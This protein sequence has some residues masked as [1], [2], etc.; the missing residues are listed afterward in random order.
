[1]SI[2]AVPRSLN[3]FGLLQALL[4]DTWVPPTSL[5]TCLFPGQRFQSRYHLQLQAASVAT[6]KLG[7]LAFQL[8]P[9]WFPQRLSAHHRPQ[10]LVS[11]LGRS[12]AAFPPAAGAQ[13]VQL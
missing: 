8:P 12:P 5:R 2:N 4:T 9:S 10:R 1:M 6:P 13:R 7:S 3:Q 11:A